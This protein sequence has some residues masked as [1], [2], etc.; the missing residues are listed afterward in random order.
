MTLR[1]RLI[2]QL[3]GALYELERPRMDNEPLEFDV[4]DTTFEFSPDDLNNEV[5]G[6]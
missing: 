5:K 2:T 4:A 6:E 3:R 1:Q